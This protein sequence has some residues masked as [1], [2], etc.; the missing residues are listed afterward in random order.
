MVEKILG[1]GE[2]LP[3]SW[4]IAGTTGYDFLWRSTGLFV[5]PAGEE[6]LGALYTELTGDARSWSEAAA[7]GKERALADLFAADL[8]RLGEL[9]AEICDA[10]VEQRDWSRAELEGALAAL[11]VAWPC[12][13]SYARGR[14]TALDPASQNTVA[15]ALRAA[16]ERSPELDPALLDFLGALLYRQLHG[17]QET[18][19]VL[20]FQQLSSALMAKG[21]EDT[22]GYAWPRLAALCEVGC[23]PGAFAVSPLDFH[24]ANGEAQRRWPRTLLATSTHDTKRSEDVRARLALLSEI[25]ARW[26]DTVRGWFARN[27]RHR[28]P[29]GPDPK[30]EYLLYQ[31]LVGAW[32]ISRERA[33]AFALKA[34]REAKERTS[35]L[36]P[37]RTFEDAVARFVDA[38]FDDR[39]FRLELERFAAELTG[40]GRVNS[41]AMLLLKLASPGVPDLYQGSELWDLSLVDPDN[42]RPVDFAARRELLAAVRAATC[43]QVIARADEGLPKL[44]V[45]QRALA[46]RRRHPERFGARSGYV[47][48]FARGVAAERVVAFA[49]RGLV[50]A[51]PRLGL[52]LDGWG[53]TELE[54]PAGRH[55]DVFSGERFAGGIV[56]V[57]RLFARFPVALLSSEEDES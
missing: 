3:A 44:F 29:A 13:R 38:L 36:A 41:L 56:P 9:L 21:V 28:S 4:P 45:I 42:R 55:R 19:L 26:A 51:V 17:P 33:A 18:E 46:E 34:A 10:R 31:T 48:L 50:C 22:A 16:K 54:L 52:R 25:P 35:W 37:D 8:A 27:L 40:A 47:P 32:P 14:D 24:G 57:A 5:D 20:R 12:Y 7:D 1:T 11:L 49:R 39:G 6:A 23:D 53:D 30:L 43:E 15:R 2:A